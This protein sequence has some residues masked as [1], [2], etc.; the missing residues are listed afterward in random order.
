MI[1]FLNFV[2]YHIHIFTFCCVLF[3]YFCK[4]NV[5]LVITGVQCR[6]LRTCDGYIWQVILEK[7]QNTGLHLA[8]FTNWII[9]CWNTRGGAWPLRQFYCLPLEFECWLHCLLAPR[10]RL[11]SL[12]GTSLSVRLVGKGFNFWQRIALENGKNITQ[13]VSFNGRLI[14]TVLM[15][16]KLY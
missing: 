6:W 11:L 1:L 2:F 5:F 8:P 7:V 4:T 10:K 12:S 9:V 3:L 16:R 13:C 15:K 14:E